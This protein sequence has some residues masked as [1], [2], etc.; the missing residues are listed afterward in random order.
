MSFRIAF[1][2]LIAA[3]SAP[4]LANAAISPLNC[5]AT[6]VPTLVRSEGISERMG[7]IVLSCSGGSPG[8]TVQGN[9]SL[10]LSVP[11]TNKRRSDDSVDL[12]L[13]IDTGSGPQAANVPAAIGG[14]FS[15]V[16]N[17]LS[18]VLP[19]SGQAIVR[20]SNLRGAPV[21]TGVTSVAAIQA[22]LA[23]NG[24]SAISV[25]NSPL[26][27][28]FPSRGLLSSASSASIVCTGS[29]LPTD[30]LTV[31]SL[32]AAG[33]RFQSTRV[34]EGYGEAFQKKD[35]TMDTGVRF[36]VSYSG[37]PTGAR[38]FVPDTVAGSNATQPTAGGD[39]GFVQ[40]G[41]SYTPSA[42]GSL[43]LA[44]VRGANADGS[45]GFPAYTPSA[46][47]SPTVT[48]DSVAEVTLRNG[49]GY[50]VYEVMDAN[51]AMRESAQWPLFLALDRLAD[52]NTVIAS[53]S[54]SFAPVSTDATISGA[55]IP[56]FSA[57]APPSDCSALNDCDADY[58]P[59][60]EVTFTPQLYRGYV[61]S[62]PQ[63]GFLSVR[64]DRG[65][66]LSWAVRLT[67][68]NGSGWIRTD[69][70]SGYNNG[71]IRLLIVPEKLP[72]GVY[73]AVITVD[74][75]PLA[76]SKD[77]PIH[78]EVVA[79]PVIPPA[80][81]V[82]KSAV[83]AA[84]FAGPLVAGSL[85]TLFGEKLAGTAVAVSFDGLPAAQ[86]FKSDTQINVLVPAQL[87]GKDK[88]QIVVTRDGTTST[89]FAVTLVSTAP[90]IF[91][92]GILNQDYGAN[93]ESRPAPAGTFIQIFAT[94]LPLQG[95]VTVKLHDLENLTPAYAGPAPG[96]DGLYQ[97]NVL[98]PDYFP[99]FTTEVLICA[100]ATDQRRACSAPVRVSLRTIE[101]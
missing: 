41:G 62:G 54:V 29:P 74:A 95:V 51:P 71:S 10:F 85:A 9:L 89:P 25:N 11:I 28:G 46:V 38:I 67:Y 80:V 32:F 60:L 61:N 86:S 73:D 50:A 39:L 92:P 75:G 98:V 16:F 88:A 76:G 22:T 87:A 66:L 37:F 23:F 69:P 100:T 43:L 26:T 20:I 77:V 27:V 24:P 3:C 83:N 18:F 47:G 13:S 72:V 68:K 8:G 65:G 44:R 58:M 64:N 30:A 96:F 7:D 36:L 14:S 81:P 45:G 59:R 99:T 90:A 70:V 48:F 97:I 49:S 1:V 56:R 63:S 52:G 4:A 91:T 82:V 55:P 31:T 84:S 42:S 94:G 6:A 78:L 12:L 53:Q 15:L 101:P 17:G 35:S 33:T 40:S 34:T 21:S 2:S 79:A 5:S 19:A 93:S 57:A